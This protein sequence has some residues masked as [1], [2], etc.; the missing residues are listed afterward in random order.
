MVHLMLKEVFYC[1]FQCW[2]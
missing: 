1:K 2:I